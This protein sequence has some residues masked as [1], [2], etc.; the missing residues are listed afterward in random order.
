MA[1]TS[2]TMFVEVRM[3]GYEAVC[4]FEPLRKLELQSWHLQWDEDAAGQVVVGVGGKHGLHGDQCVV[5]AAIRECAVTRD[6]LGS[7]RPEVCGL[8]V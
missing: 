2:L 8:E 7:T 4:G 6:I 3:S 1:G 5:S